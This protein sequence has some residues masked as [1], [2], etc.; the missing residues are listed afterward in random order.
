MAIERLLREVRLL[1]VEVTAGACETFTVTEIE[2]LR[3]VQSGKVTMS[4]LHA[5]LGYSK[6]NLTHI[7]DK[8]SIKKLIRRVKIERRN[9]TELHLTSKG[10]EAIALFSSLEEETRRRLCERHKIARPV[11]DAIIDAITSNQ[12]ASG[13]SKPAP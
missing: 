6:P 9:A 11:L 5:V 7:T 3:A 4:R 2:V 10:I 12:Y 8:L 13:E 1:D